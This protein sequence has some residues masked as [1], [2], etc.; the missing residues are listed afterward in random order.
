MS[1]KTENTI[2]YGL[3]MWFLAMIGAPTLFL[4]DVNNH[5]WI[6]FVFKLWLLVMGGPPLIGMFVVGYFLVKN[7][8]N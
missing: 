4:L 6:I 8:R 5:E 1:Y 2:F 3:V 7:L